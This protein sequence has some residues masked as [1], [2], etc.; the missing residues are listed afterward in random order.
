MAFVQK[1]QGSKNR[2]GRKRKKK[3]KE[4]RAEA[5]KAKP[6]KKTSSANGIVSEGWKTGVKNGQLAVGCQNLL[7][8]F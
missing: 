3:F 7:D 6:K 1:E 4:E 5:E 2:R 8:F